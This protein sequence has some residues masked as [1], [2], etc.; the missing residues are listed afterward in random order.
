[1]R[2]LSTHDYQNLIR[3]LLS[4]FPLLN[5][6]VGRF[7]EGSP[8]ERIPLF[9][10]L[11]MA[12]ATKG[13]PGMSCFVLD[14]TQGTAAL[15]AIFLGLA[16]LE[17]DF[18]LLA[19][20]YA[21]TAFDKGQHVLVKPTNFVYEYDGLWEGHP[22]LFRLKVL[23]RPEWRSFQVSEALRLEPTTRQRPKGR[24]S[25]NL[26]V[27]ERSGLDDLLDITTYGNDSMIRNIVLLYTAQARFSKIAD[28]VSL[29]PVHSDQ[30]HRL[31]DFL[32]WGSIG[33]GGEI[34]VG[35]S[36]QVVGEPLIAVT[37]VP[38]DLADAATSAPEA[39][40]IVLVDGARGIASDP[41]SFDDIAE[42]QRVIV[43]ASPDEVDEIRLLRDRD[44]PIWHMSPAEITMGEAHPEQRDRRSLLGRTVR[45]AEIKEH[46]QVTAMHCES[47]E[48]QMAATDLESVASRIDGAEERED[49]DDL[50][51]RLY[52]LLMDY[53]ECC[54]GIDSEAES[55]LQQVQDILMRDR[56]W[57][58]SDVIRGLQ[59]TIDRLGSVSG[60]SKA[61]VMLNIL[62]ESTGRWMI[63]SRSARTAAAIR[64][65][66]SSRG[67]EVPVFP[68]QTISPEDEW[69]GLIVPAW[70][71]RRRFTRLRDLASAR[72]VL[73]LVY[74]FEDRW[75]VGY[76]NRERNVMLGNRMEA[77]ERAAILGVHTELLPE[78]E[79]EERDPPT[80]DTTVDPPVF[81]LERR[82]SQ[83]R[84]N[85][86]SVSDGNREV[87][88][89]RVVEF[90]G[91]CYALLT[92]WSQVHVLNDLINL[93]QGAGGRLRTAVATD[94]SYDD[95]VLFRSG[96]DK[97]FIRMLAEQE[98]GT[99]EYERIRTTAERWKQSLRRLGGTPTMIHR[100]LERSGL[101]RTLQAVRG[102]MENPSLIGP[103][104]DSDIE[105][106]A[107][108]ARDP[109]L[110]EQM[111]SVREAIS[112][113]RGA[114]IG[115]GSRLTQL[116]LNEVRGHLGQLDGQPVLLD[117]GY[118]QAWVVQV[119]SVDATLRD[120]P[121]DQ[122][123]RLLGVD[124]SIF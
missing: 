103:G 29:G 50:L 78:V 40:R 116:I 45:V 20:Q 49:L 108:A 46:S 84:S 32:P 18:P 9:F 53:S 82:V 93:G 36:Y 95:F 99:E 44:Y 52:R 94:L 97:E 60:G 75:L 38:Q 4:R 105:S 89:A 51:I 88:R 106:I 12:A 34:R 77:R 124:D 87:R 57:L 111:E 63:A 120:Y 81:N 56:M 86:P 5:R 7:G 123:N 61:G 90:H 55:D 101:N 91:G 98:I 48:L 96:G 43:L 122:T 59:T 16:R 58:H 62:T 6:V 100:T 13:E 76:Q 110:L 102:W 65:G 33:P 118:G 73:L 107:R 8:N 112:R 67:V 15:T 42:R 117:L 25:S 80:A 104:Y 109:R 47:E 23:D 114:H 41:Q 37:R 14:R 3:E 22:G 35:D 26:G 1:M 119:A 17:E 64:D 10:A 83:R 39:S 11:L 72:E 19:E 71:G 27:F 66:L 79:L 24:L 2:E 74:P 121:A 92:E 113:I 54:F 30:S 70:P 69:D 68:I 115:A 21:R 28:V 31:S 85:R